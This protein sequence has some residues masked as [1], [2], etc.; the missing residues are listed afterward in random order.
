[1]KTKRKINNRKMVRLAEL[2]IE[3]DHPWEVT[4]FMLQE[5]ERLIALEERSHNYG[6][7]PQTGRVERT[8]P[9]FDY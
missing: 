4:P 2:P 3:I 9:Q 8:R 7:N 1:M 5:K 6:Y